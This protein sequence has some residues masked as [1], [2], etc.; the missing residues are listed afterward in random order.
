MWL[1]LFTQKDSPRLIR[2]RKS[3]NL[4][5]VRFVDE[6]D[7]SQ[8][9]RFLFYPLSA[10]RATSLALPEA[11]CALLIF[12]IPWEYLSKIMLRVW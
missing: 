1:A 4:A 10:L 6:F 5:A 8:I 9:R 7:H 12:K 11:T 2:P 3:T